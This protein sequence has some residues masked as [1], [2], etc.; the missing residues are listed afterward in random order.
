MYVVDADVDGDLPEVAGRCERVDHR[1]ATA[2][3]AAAAAP[4]KGDPPP[5]AGGTKG[6]AV[7]VGAGP[8]GL[9]AA[10][11][12]AADG[13]RVTVLERGEPVEVRGRDIGRLMARRELV[14]ESNFC[15]GEGGAGTWSDGKLTTR[16]GRN[17]AD[18]RAV[19]RTLVFHGAPREIL[20]MGSPH[21]GTDGLIGILK[22]CRRR[23]LENGVD[24]RFG[25][26]VTAFERDAS[27]ACVGVR[28]AASGAAPRLIKADARA[29]KGCEIPNFKGSYLGRFPLVLA[30]FWTSDH[31]SERSRP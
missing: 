18:V 29:G 17:A 9:F 20:T 5:G 15:F 26:R 2:G 8:A 22:S 23:L 14:E 24:V 19:L 11:Q 6:T 10:L 12:L 25:A 1:G 31:L 13:V 3:A 16:I 4:T 21:L 7:V 27:G 28:V 30:D